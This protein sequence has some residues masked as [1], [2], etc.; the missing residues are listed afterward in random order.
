M[1]VS[2]IKIAD[3]FIGDNS[4]FFVES[5]LVDKPI[6][7]YNHQNCEFLNQKVGLLY[8]KSAVNF[9]TIKDLINGFDKVIKDGDVLA[10]NRKKVVDFFLF[11]PGKV[12]SY[13]VKSLKV[14]G[15]S[16]GPKSRSWRRV[17]RYCAVERDKS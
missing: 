11:Q 6:F 14:M 4:S 8:K 9:S 5:C 12:T 2:A 10:G 3:F 17:L 7:F 15:R 1:T 16:S 13:I